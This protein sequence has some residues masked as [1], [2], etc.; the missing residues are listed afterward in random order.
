MASERAA[1]A[2]KH[3]C[4][5]LSDAIGHSDAHAA[6][7]VYDTQCALAADLAEAYR[8]CLPRARFIDFDAVTPEEVRAAF[9]PLVPSDLVVLIQ[10]TN[11]RLE[12]FR[13]RVDL[14]NRSLK[15]IEHPHLSRMAGAEADYY[16][17]SLAYDREYYRG[18]GL[19]L[20]ARIDRAVTGAVES[21]HGVLHFVKRIL[22]V[23]QICLGSGEILAS[24]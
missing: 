16:V 3:V 13:I 4:A 18:T 1:V 10:S 20:K 5:I 24:E 19:A 22:Q 11:F 23:R 21:G 7:V 6:V 14:F 12:A 2:E 15:V 9:E 17:D 8:G